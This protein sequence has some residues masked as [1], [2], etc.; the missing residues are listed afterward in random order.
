MTGARMTPGLRMLDKWCEAKATKA[1][2]QWAQEKDP[3]KRQRL[4]GEQRAFLRMRS[5]IHGSAQHQ[6]GSNQ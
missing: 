1:A 5:F 4:L 2:L 3:D 6:P